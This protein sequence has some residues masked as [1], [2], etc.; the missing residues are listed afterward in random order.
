M[1]STTKTLG[2]DLRFAVPIQIPFDNLTVLKWVAVLS[3]V[4]DHVRYLPGM[5]LSWLFP[6]GRLAFPLFAFVLAAHVARAYV[7]GEDDML[8]RLMRRLFIFGLF[9]Q[10]FSMLLF[11]VD[12][13]HL[14]IMFT[15]ALC[16]ALY[17]M[18]FAYALAA[19][20]LLGALVDYSWPGI[21]FFVA[22]V[23]F[24]R[25][26]ITREYLPFALAGLLGGFILISL[27]VS[28]FAS[29][30]ALPLL[31][32]SVVGRMPVPMPRWGWFFYVFY[33]LHLMV[34]V[35]LRPFMH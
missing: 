5:N 17:R 12:V 10:A 13:L 16:V 7:S 11:R 30:A 35:A 28:T 2:I 34:L 18:P 21:F 23:T 26:L 4:A 3:M 24:H 31:Y 20:M 8:D 15:F 9:A 14:N 27:T 6:L 1:N 25:A 32:W 29:L 33:P 19:G 22:S